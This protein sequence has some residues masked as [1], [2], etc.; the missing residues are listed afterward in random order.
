MVYL[1]LGVIAIIFAIAIYLFVKKR[2]EAKI[3][4]EIEAAGGWENYEA[5][6]KKEI[7]KE[8]AAIKEV[9]DAKREKVFTDLLQTNQELEDKHAFKEK[10]VQFQSYKD[11][12]SGII[13]LRSFDYSNREGAQWIVSE[14]SIIIQCQKT[15]KRTQIQMTDIHNSGWHLK[16]VEVNLDWL[17]FQLSGSTDTLFKH[18][19][20]YPYYFLIHMSER[21]FTKEVFSRIQQYAPEQVTLEPTFDSRLRELS[22]LLKENRITQ[23][24][25][26]NGV[27]QS[28]G[29]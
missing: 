13:Y 14:D 12:T 2:K 5:M 25:F 16:K 1:I 8:N 28:L 19:T 15:G 23:E 7:E 3:W 6:L 26:E 17:S 29:I 27:R 4:A 22:F 10:P 24:E 9:F 11:D 18:A 20:T 21:E